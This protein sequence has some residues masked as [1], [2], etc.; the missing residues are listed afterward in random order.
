MNFKKKSCYL[1]LLLIIATILVLSFYFDREII[2]FIS[3]LRNIYLSD[4]FFGVKFLDNEIIIVGFLTI[5]LLWR[6]KSRKWVLPLWV[7]MGITAITSL[8]L[9]ILVR[10]TRPFMQ[11]VITLLPGILDELKYHI[12]DFSFPSF[13]T[14]FAFSA[15]P[16]L[17]KLYPKFKYVWIIFAT[18]IALS[19]IYFGLHFLSDIISGALIGIL[20][21]FI[22]VKVED[23][24][25]IFQK[26]Y[27]KIS[28]GK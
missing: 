21:G 6:K 2:K 25:K 19:R 7:S 1:I 11:G 3:S 10:R 27:N 28:K 9:K 17:S 23:E 8:I 26:F 15:V 12:W 4:L 14:A 22:I 20:I 13:D 16:I 24:K 5:L 18:L